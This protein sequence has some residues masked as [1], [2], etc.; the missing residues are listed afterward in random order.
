MLTTVIK[1]DLEMGSKEDFQSSVRWFYSENSNSATTIV[2]RRDEVPFF[3]LERGP[4]SPAR[5]SGLSA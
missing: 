1:N 2:Q 3:T 5:L 4:F